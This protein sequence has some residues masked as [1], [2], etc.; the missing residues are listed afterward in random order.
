M[1]RPEFWET[2]SIRNLKHSL[3]I[4]NKLDTSTPFGKYPPK[5]QR[6]VGQRNP[7]KNRN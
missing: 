3:H 2:T 5:R 4:K 7:D 1:F 6:Y